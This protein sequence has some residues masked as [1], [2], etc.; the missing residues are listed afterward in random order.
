[1]QKIRTGEQM[2][3]ESNERMERQERELRRRGVLD[4]GNNP[5]EMNMLGYG[6]YDPRATTS[7]YLAALRMLPPP[8]KLGLQ[9]KNIISPSGNKKDDSVLSDVASN[10]SSLEIDKA[11]TEM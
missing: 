11:A 8:W 7:S 1:L 5:N 9:R 3:K 10:V 6:Q 4:H 2:Q